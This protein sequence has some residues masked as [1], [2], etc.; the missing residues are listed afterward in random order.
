MSSATLTCLERPVDLP[1]EPLTCIQLVPEKNDTLETYLRTGL[2]LMEKA[3]AAKGFSPPR[4][5]LIY[6]TYW[7]S[8]I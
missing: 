8:P 3:R 7:Y 6:K 2:G 1:D 5:I 4:K